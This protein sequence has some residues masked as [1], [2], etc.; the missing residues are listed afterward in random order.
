MLFPDVLNIKIQASIRV[1]QENEPPEGYFFAF[2]GGKDSIVVYLLLLLA[3]VKFTAYFNRTTVDPPELISYIR[4]NYPETVFLRPQLTMFQLIEAKRMLPTRIIKF[5]CGALKEY[6]G[7]G[8]WVVTGIRAEESARRAKRRMIEDKKKDDRGQ[9]VP[10]SKGFVNPIFLWTELDVW[11]FIDANKIKY[12]ELYDIEGINRI[13][14]VGCPCQPV[15]T[16]KA[17]FKRYPG[18]KKAYINT[19]EK[20]RQK[21]N[22]FREFP[23]SKSVF[24][25]WINDM[26]VEEYKF[27]KK[28]LEDQCFI[29]TQHQLS[30][31][32]KSQKDQ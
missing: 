4:E 30:L 16:R 14:C 6:S 5:C 28:L 26:S 29:S 19:I 21:H 7:K 22:L 12:C 11:T 3:G 13:G 17:E 8:R 25:W 18:F 9:I 23:D 31:T 27:N 32:Q 24:E 1:L 2:S 20:L 10:G 15:R